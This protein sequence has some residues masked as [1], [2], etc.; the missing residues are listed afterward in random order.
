MVRGVSFVTVIAAATAMGQAQI[1]GVE[2][3]LSA[4]PSV[5]PVAASLGLYLPGE[6]VPI[7]VSL[8]TTNAAIPDVRAIQV[9]YRASGPTVINYNSGAIVPGF[10]L[11]IVQFDEYRFLASSP[12]IPSPLTLPVAPNSIGFM[13][14]TANAPGAANQTVTV[15]LLGICSPVPEI[16]GTAVF[17]GGG[18][19]WS[20]C[21]GPSAYPVV[22]GVTSIATVPE[23][24]VPIGLLIAAARTARRRHGCASGA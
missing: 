7:T 22:G 14:L 20:N 3:V 8:R 13:T 17:A 2:L 11:T 23:P 16:D 12:V 24:G 1:N 9:D 5:D 15:N 10:P 21:P 19:V 18:L 4:A 6:V